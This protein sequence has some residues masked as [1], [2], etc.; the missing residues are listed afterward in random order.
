MGRVL[1]MIGP[2]T[3]ISVPLAILR[4]GPIFEKFSTVP[5]RKPLPRA[6]YLAELREFVQKARPIHVWGHQRVLLQNPG[7]SDL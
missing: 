1:L 4:H 2:R 3:L 6:I 7:V 5:Y